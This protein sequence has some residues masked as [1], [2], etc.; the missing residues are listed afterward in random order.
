MKAQRRQPVF[1]FFLFSVALSVPAQTQPVN[2]TI[3]GSQ[4]YAPISKYV[5]GQFIEHLGGII[6]NG[7]WAEML[8]DRKF[9]YPIMF[10]TQALAARARDSHRGHWNFVGPEAAV[11]MDTHAP[12]VG[13]HSPQVVL[14]G[15]EKRGLHNPDLPC[16][17]ENPTP[18]ALCSRVPGAPMFP[19]V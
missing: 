13:E 19:S 7:M 10:Q 11:S 5:Y 4:T 12:F 2:V 6:N 14:N 1:F 15:N 18:V 8:D 16:V 17:T 3:D 9:Y